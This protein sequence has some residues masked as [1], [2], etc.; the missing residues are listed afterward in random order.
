MRE[1]YVLK[2]QIHNPDN[3]TYMEALSVENAE[4]YYKAMYDEIHSLIRRY[5]WEI[6][7]EVRFW[8]Q[9]AS[10][11]MVFQVPEE[12]WF[13]NQ[14]IQGTILCERGCLEETAS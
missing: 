4:E 6:F 13:D 8:L 3:P 9:C 7:K 14:E 12:T 1:S 5:T 10:R 11:N 2:T